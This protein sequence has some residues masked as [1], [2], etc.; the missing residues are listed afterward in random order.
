M[1]DT[2]K[3]KNGLIMPSNFIEVKDG[4]MEYLDGGMNAL[5]ITAL[6]FGTILIGWAPALA[7]ISGGA[8]GVT[9]ICAGISLICWAFNV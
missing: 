1:T 5:G 9:A 7:C 4:A 6:F 8:L 2:L 3:L